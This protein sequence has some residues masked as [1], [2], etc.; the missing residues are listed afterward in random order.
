MLRLGR[1][2]DYAVTLLSHMG[3]GGEEALWAASGLAEKSGLSM[4]TT[5]KILKLLA[6][7]G[8]VSAQRGAT[9]G[10][11]LAR[12]APEISIAEIIEIMDGPIAIT[13]C[14]HGSAHENCKIRRL[15][16]MSVGWNKVNLAVRG[17]LE[18]VSLAEMFVMPL[19]PGEY[20]MSSKNPQRKS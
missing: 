20:D 9:G 6:K 14:S 5:A 11:K 17:A 18:N 7:G 16:P 4:P 13:D 12:R 1:L 10:Y 3:N 8:L 19:L 15:C 2:T